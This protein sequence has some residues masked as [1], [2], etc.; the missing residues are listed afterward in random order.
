MKNKKILLLSKISKIKDDCNKW[1]T[2]TI[3]PYHTLYLIEM[4]GRIKELENFV[5]EWDAERK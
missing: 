4:I 3:S 2:K 5:E 1:Q